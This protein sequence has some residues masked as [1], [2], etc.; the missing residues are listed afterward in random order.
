MTDPTASYAAGF[1]QTHAGTETGQFTGRLTGTFGSAFAD[2]SPSAD[3]TQ[4][5][6]GQRLDDFD[7]LIEL[8]RGAFARVFLARQLSLQRL[9]AVKIS[10]N[11]GH[12][13]Q[14]LAQLDHDH[15]VRVFDQH[16]LRDRDWRLLY[17]QYLP[18]GTLLDVGRVIFA[19]EQRPDSGQALLDAVDIALES[20]GESRPTQSITRAELATLSWPETVAW[21]GKRLAGALHY[22]NS[23]GVLHRD[24]KPAN[25]LLTRD[26]T[27]KLADFNVSFSRNVEGASPFDYFG[28]SLSY[29]SPEQLTACQPGHTLEQADLDTRSDIYSLAVVLWELLTGMK[30]FDDSAAQ[31]ARA[32]SAGLVGDGTALELMLTTRAE[33]ISS[34]ALA[35][36]PSDCPTALRRVLRK[37]LSAER[38]QRWGSGA[39]FAEQL[40]LCL[41]PHA[42]DLVDPPA[43]SWRLRLRPFILPVSALAVLIPVM[44]AGAYNIQH[45]Q[46][47]IVSH[48][49]EQAQSRFFLVTTLIN[50]IFFPL[51]AAV[52][53]YWCRYV[54][55]VPRRLRRGPAPP[56]EALARARHDCLVMGDRVVLVVFGLVFVSALTFPLLMQLFAGGISARSAIHFFG[57]ITVCGAIAIAYPFFLLTFYIVRSVYPE[58]VAYGQTSV[59]EAEQLEALSRRLPRYLAVAASVPLL[60][61]V[62]VSFLT[63]SEI[64]A[65]IVPVRVLCIGG[66]AGFVLA[67]WLSRQIESDIRALERVICQRAPYEIPH[68]IRRAPLR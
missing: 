26:G 45:N 22:A 3:F 64:A 59:G 58:L 54:I 18:G 61:I 38:D 2:I 50:L 42:R 1:T 17:M 57:S 11:R 6:P 68:S 32:G 39:E 40:Q 43:R 37:A 62:A 60:G 65:V 52:V 44:L 13:P 10:A 55:L 9:V 41:D 48:L 31:A 19:G 33:G 34:A 8:G 4:L 7:L 67:Y 29:M 12:E 28:G 47:L 56:A 63:A 14:T 21:L 66:I 24:V 30:P 23:R 49:S 20:R 46:L 25:V 5:E 16:V 35:A 15:I 51:G 27:P 36:L 53:V